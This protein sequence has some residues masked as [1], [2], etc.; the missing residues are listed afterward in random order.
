MNTHSKTLLRF[1]A[2]FGLIGAMMGGHMA[3]AG[4]YAFRPIHAHI[5]VVGWLT[6]FGWAVFYKVFRIS[7]NFMTRL[8]VRTAIVGSV[9]L[10]AGMWLY[11]VKPFP[12]PEAFTLILYIGG[13]VALLVS[14]LVFFLITLSVRD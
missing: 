4:S 6:L 12:L 11:M 1:A 5:L 13:G 10:T 14:F 7:E 9:G 2:L 3:G 8:Q